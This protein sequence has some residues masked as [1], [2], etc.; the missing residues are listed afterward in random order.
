MTHLK[1]MPNVR[2]CMTRSQN[3]SF[4]F[5]LTLT[6]TETST[7]LPLCEQPKLSVFFWR[8]ESVMKY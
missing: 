6:Q 2:N 7:P 5:S 8:H 4:L 1:N 3:A